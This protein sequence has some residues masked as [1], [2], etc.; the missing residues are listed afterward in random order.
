MAQ[1]VSLIVSP[2]LS[3]NYRK[4]V[5]T[6]MKTACFVKTSIKADVSNVPEIFHRYK[7]NK[8]KTYDKFMPGFGN[9]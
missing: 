7:N 5:S 9:F 3:K 4:I 1:V 2:K 6:F 8:S